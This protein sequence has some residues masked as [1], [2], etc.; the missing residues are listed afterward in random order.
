MRPFRHE[1]CCHPTFSLKYL[2]N[3]DL[4]QLGAAVTAEIHRRGQDV[5]KSDASPP[6]S[7]SAT[8]RNTVSTVEEL[9]EG[10]ANLIRASL[11]AGVEPAAIARIFQLPQSLANR[12]I[13]STDK[14][15]REA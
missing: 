4:Q 10:K 12:V 15:W 13:N 11:R 6:I 5:T 3:A 2:D 14:R 9:P 7:P 8:I 1:S